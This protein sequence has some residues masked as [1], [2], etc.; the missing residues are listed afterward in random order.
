MH[1][2][3]CQKATLLYYFFHFIF[4]TG[5]VLL[6]NS[7][8]LMSEHFTLDV[9]RTLSIECVNIFLSKEISD[10]AIGYMIFS[11][12]VKSKYVCPCQK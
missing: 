2:H 11:P 1:E 10:G 12:D 6:K 9:M 7:E 4:S 5:L 3:T 8:L